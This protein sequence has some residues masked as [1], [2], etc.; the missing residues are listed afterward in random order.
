MTTMLNDSDGFRKGGCHGG[1]SHCAGQHAKPMYRIA[2]T[3][4]ITE[5]IVSHGL[6]L[7]INNSVALGVGTG[8]CF[9]TRSDRFTKIIDY[10]H[11]GCNM[12]QFHRGIICI[13]GAL[14]SRRMEV[15]RTDLRELLWFWKYCSQTSWRYPSTFY[16]ERLESSFL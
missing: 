8:T 15:L 13:S 1:C 9:I 10:L 6:S 3:I 7:L 2:V 4:Q 16:V 12:R 14:V 5:E 11:S